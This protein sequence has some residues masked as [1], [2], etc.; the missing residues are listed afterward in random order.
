MP[1]RSRHRRRWLGRIHSAIAGA[2]TGNE[3]HAGPA[4]MPVDLHNRT[5]QNGSALAASRPLIIARAAAASQALVVIPSRQ[6]RVRWYH[7]DHLVTFLRPD[8]HR[9]EADVAGGIG[10]Q[11][12]IEW[13]Q[14]KRSQGVLEC[15][16]GANP[17][18]VRWP[19]VRGPTLP[20]QDAQPRLTIP[21]EC[22]ERS[23]ARLRYPEVSKVC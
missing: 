4:G 23:L 14:R 15:D 9:V 5:R 12:R 10:C 17:G 11:P 3:A 19:R 13:R 8:R 20:F 7:A 1:A 21:E 18:P 22:Q 6:P 2:E 16:G